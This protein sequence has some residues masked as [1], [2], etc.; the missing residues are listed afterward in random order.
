MMNSYVAH[1]IFH[2]DDLRENLRGKNVLS[3]WKKNIF[4]F[5]GHNVPKQTNPM[6]FP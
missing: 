4:V 1:W 2:W 5:S 6:N 3:P